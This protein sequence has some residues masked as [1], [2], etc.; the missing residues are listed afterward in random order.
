MSLFR[1]KNEIENWLKQ[2]NIV[3][4]N[5]I[6][7]IEY[8]YVVNV[9]Q[10][11]KLIATKLVEI[12]VKFNI[13]NG[14][15][16]CS[17]NKLTSLKGSPESVKNF[18]CYTNKLETLEFS[19][20]IVTQ[21]FHCVDNQLTSLIGSPKIVDSFY[22]S[23]NKLTSLEYCPENIFCSLNAEKNQL[24]TIRF[25]PINIRLKMID[26]SDNIELGNLQSCSNFRI[27]KQ[28]QELE[29]L[30]E[31]L[32]ETLNYKLNKRLNKI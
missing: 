30:K 11:V 21:A 15:F 1:E 27:L 8:G 25:L 28:F 31:K 26:I 3:N 6:E 7:D 9:N 23:E 12:K 20:K 22:C 18:Y 5:L 10:T 13:I 32:D 14:D 19:P 29:F 16:D 4:F 2:Y 24:N 17:R